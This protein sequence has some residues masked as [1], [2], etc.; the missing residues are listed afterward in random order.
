[1]F[2]IAD[3]RAPSPQVKENPGRALGSS[4]FAMRR[5]GNHCS[6]STMSRSTHSCSPTPRPCRA[7]DAV[8]RCGPRGSAMPKESSSGSSMERIGSASSSSRDHSNTRMQRSSLR[9]STRSISWKARHAISIQRLAP[10]G[11]SITIGSQMD[12]TSSKSGL[13][14]GTV[15]SD[16]SWRS[17]GARC[18][19]PT[20]RSC[21][22]TGRSP[23]ARSGCP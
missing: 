2:F 6:S 13:R 23:C 21:S 3:H 20:E 19:R 14:R 15:S 9:P 12:R 22:E 8:H 16:S 11:A 17:A 7:R 1:M 4:R 10:R 5:Q 18:R